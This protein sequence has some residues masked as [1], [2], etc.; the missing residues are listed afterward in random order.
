MTM[1]R[2][3]FSI[4]SFFITVGVILVMIFADDAVDLT[5]E[6]RVEEVVKLQFSKHN[7]EMMNH[8]LATAD[9]EE[10]PPELDE[11]VRFM[12]GYHMEDK[13]L[14]D[15]MKEYGTSYHRNAHSNGYVIGLRGLDVVQ[16]QDD[17]AVYNF[18]ASVS[19]QKGQNEAIVKDVQGYAEFLNSDKEISQFAYTNDNGLS[20]ALKT[21]SIK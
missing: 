7:K 3:I 5:P 19:Y 8:I 10:Y 16:T 9:G 21:K 17:P 13:A 6:Q 12:N 18:T 14:D 20:E 15:Y 1:N 2:I 4:V 11:H